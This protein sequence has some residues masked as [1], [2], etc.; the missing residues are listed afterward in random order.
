MTSPSPVTSSP[1]ATPSEVPQPLHAHIRGL[2]GTPRIVCP[3][4]PR[5]E[6]AVDSRG[7]LHLLAYAETPVAMATVAS[8][9]AASSWAKAHAPLI[10]LAMQGLGIPFDDRHAADLHLLTSTAKE[11]RGLAETGVHIHLLARVEIEGRQG[12]FCTEIG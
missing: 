7:G 11:S 10:A 3:A 6:T 5:I 2:T 4:H 8:L 1:A 9:I 12:W